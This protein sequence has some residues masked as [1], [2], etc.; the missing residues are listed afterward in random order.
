MRIITNNKPRPLFSGYELTNA[1]RREL[2]YIAPPDDV[3]TWCEQHNRFFRYR[4]NVYDIQEFTRIVRQSDR[5][6]PF[7]HGVWE[8][9]SPLLNWDGIQTDSY[10]SGVVIRYVPDSGYCDIVVGLAIS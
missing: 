5:V 3:E 9:N 2:D 6:N 10:F 4:G 7:E 8:E 1:E